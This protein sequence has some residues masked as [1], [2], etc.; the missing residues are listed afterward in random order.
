M[1]RSR[2]VLLPVL[3]FAASCGPSQS[4]PFPPRPTL[5]HYTFR[6]IGGVSMGGMGS[7][8]IGTSHPEL[9]DAI[10]S[11]GGPMDFAYLLHFIESSDIGGFCTLPELQALLAQDPTG[12]ILND[13]AALSCMK[14]PPP[15]VTPY[16]HTEDFNHWRYTNNGGNFDRD[17]YMSL[18]E[19]ISSAFGNPLS[20]NPKSSFFAPGIDLS[21]WQRGEDLCVHPFVIPGKAKGGSAPVYNAEFNPAGQYDAVLFCDG[22]RPI[23]YCANDPTTE[24]DWCQITA[25][26]QGSP[27][28]FCEAKGGAVQAGEQ[29]PDAALFFAEQGT[30]DPCYPSTRP[31]AVSLAIDLNGN[32]KRDYGEPVIVNSHERFQ[33]VGVDGCPDALE[34]GKGGCVT[35]PTKSPFAQGVLDPNGDDYDFEKNP[36]GTENDWRREEGE[37][38]ADDGLDGVPGTGDFGEGNGT[39]DVEPAYQAYFRVD[40]R[41]NIRDR[42]PGIGLDGQHVPQLDRVDYLIDGGVRDVFNFGVSGAQIY[43]LLKS[44]LGPSQVSRFADFSSWPSATA[45]FN[46]VSFD[47]SQANWS[48]IPRDLFTFYG[49]LDATPAEIAQGDGDHVGTIAQALDRFDALYNWLARRWDGVAQDVAAGSNPEDFATRSSIQ[50]FPSQSL[51]VPRDFGIVLPPGYDSPE[52]A[53]ARYPVAYVLHGYG[54]APADMMGTEVI[55]DGQML[56]GS[57]RKMIMVY[58]SGRCCF[59]NVSTGELGCTEQLNGQPRSAPWV[60]ECNSGNFYVDSQ[61]GPAGVPR[62][63]EQSFL[64][65]LQWVDQNYRTLAASGGVDVSVH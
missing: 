7:S 22:Q 15:Q 32:G 33:D 10:G 41:T 59:T 17:S 3:L 30:H 4:S 45:P 51:G 63:Y 47:A 25:A 27:Q 18:F 54:Q 40:P 52:N 1:T 14:P 60:R 24:V 46:D 11:L 39:F 58:P 50:T 2:R 21:V 62:T 5:R 31:M 16:E 26:P 64:E 65:L 6:A 48:L 43:G 20:Y 8:F 36:L 42:W 28:S 13:P 12:A 19:D 34:D 38:F 61:G 49:S 56:S 29:G 35:D 57:L 55:Y 44:L 53:Q 37:P 23:W 9:F